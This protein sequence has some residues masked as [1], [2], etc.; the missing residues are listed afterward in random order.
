MLEDAKKEA[1][2]ITDA[3]Q[4]LREMIDLMSSMFDKYEIGGVSEQKDSNS[5]EEN[6]EASIE[7]TQNR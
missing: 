7:H 4:S 5:I 3:S 1:S 2:L 6:Q